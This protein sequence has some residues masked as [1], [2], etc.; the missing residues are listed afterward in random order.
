MYDK[1][2]F[3]DYTFFDKKHPTYIGTEV[4]S[5]IDS[6]N[7]QLEDK[8]RNT[9]VKKLKSIKYTPPLKTAF[10]MQIQKICN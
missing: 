5:D 9:T 2:S 8:L 7:Q 1:S 10:E 3:N 4:N 6:E